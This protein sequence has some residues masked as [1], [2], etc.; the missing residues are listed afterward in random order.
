M[1]I[2]DGIEQSSDGQ[3][4]LNRHTQ[5]YN[6]ANADDDDGDAT[7]HF[8]CYDYFR[9]FFV[10]LFFGVV[11]RFHSNSHCICL[12]LSTRIRHD[13]STFYSLYS[14]HFS[15]A[16]EFEA[17]PEWEARGR[18]RAKIEKA[19][20]VGDWA[21]KYSDFAFTILYLVCNGFHFDNKIQ[22]LYYLSQHYAGNV[23]NF[24]VFGGPRVFSAVDTNFWFF[25]MSFFL[26]PRLWTERKNES[27]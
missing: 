6:I 19:N 24:I 11:A 25:V 5:T 16:K 21:I 20:I 14:L 1:S 15:T 18:K 3:W 22:V 10:R 7:N 13:A 26:A 27:E 2:R 12:R 4:S 8:Y 9:F 17:M 23:F